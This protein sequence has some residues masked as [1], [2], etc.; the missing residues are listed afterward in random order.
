MRF[1]TPKFW[2]NKSIVSCLLRPVSS[3]YYALISCR[4]QNTLPYHSRLP[5]LCIGNAVIGGAGKTPTAISLCHLLKQ[6]G[7]HPA[8]ISRG[9]GGS[10]S[11]EHAL[12]VNP[13]HHN[14]MQVG[15]EPLLLAKHAPVFIGKDRVAAVKLAEQKEGVDV[16]IM[17]DGLQNQTI[18]K[19]ASLLVMQGNYGIGNGYLFP[20]GPLRE[21]LTKALEKTQAVLIIGDDTSGTAEIVGNKPIF[22]GQLE[23]DE[24]LFPPSDKTYVA[25]A[26]IAHPSRFF[27]TLKE[28]NYTIAK[29]IAFADHYPYKPK[30][31]GMLNELAQKHCASLITTEKDWVRLANHSKEQIY[32]LPVVLSIKD[33]A[34]IT[35]WLEKNLVSQDSR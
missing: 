35:K 2:Q 29:T 30:D 4:K 28:R 11:K 3:L 6:Q 31:M 19:T 5:L 15:D 20:A 25:F 17:D 12:E 7:Y 26:G 23:V 1:K 9:Y 13:K 33:E 27:A 21:P 18:E 10:L 24:T 8:F 14:A 16:L 32:Q 34:L 22:F